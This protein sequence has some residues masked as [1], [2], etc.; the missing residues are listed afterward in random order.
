MHLLRTMEAAIPAH[1]VLHSLHTEAIRD[2]A[3]REL[4]A[5]HRFDTQSLKYLNAMMAAAGY[6]RRILSGDQSEPVRIGLRDQLGMLQ[7]ARDATEAALRELAESEAGRANAAVQTM[8]QVARLVDRAHRAI[9][10]AAEPL[11]TME[12][13]EE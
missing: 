4:P 9:M 13:G 2:P 8:I 3:V 6:I 7:P 5:M 12:V 1:E 10:A 11:V